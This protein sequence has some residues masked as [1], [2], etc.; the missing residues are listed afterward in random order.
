M[1]NEL[2]NQIDLENMPP[3]MN[4]QSLVLMMIAV[5]VGTALATMILPSWLPG[6]AA[7]LLGP[8]PQVYWF[9]SRSSA[10][11]AYF[12]LWFSMV[13]GVMITNKMARIWPGGP[14]AY[15][16]HQHASLLGLAYALFHGLIL[17]GDK[18]INFNLAQVLTP[19]AS[20]NYSPIWVGLGQIGFY[21]WGGVVLSFY[22][23]K[24]IGRRGWRLIHFTSFLVYL[25]AL[26]HGITSGTDSGTL[27]MS[28]WYWFSGGSLLFLTIYRVLVS[29]HSPVLETTA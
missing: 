17:I 21:L 22:V 26:L 28:L 1:S 27:G 11:I 2:S 18:Y 12:L 24:N 7:S 8:N 5:V 10:I 13:L 6:L 14:L 29:L 19:F 16:L 15:D 4:F 25:A 23:R 20:L 3:A 9:L